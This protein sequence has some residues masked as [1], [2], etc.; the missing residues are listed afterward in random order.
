MINYNTNILH[1]NLYSKFILKFFKKF[2]IIV[3]HP[4]EEILWIILT[5]L[6]SHVVCAN[7][8]VRQIGLLSTG[9]GAKQQYVTIG[10]N[11]EKNMWSLGKDTSLVI[12]GL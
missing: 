6:V 10:R 7:Q 12:N 5:E 8:N 2:L 3:S 11:S 9:I 1:I 4:S